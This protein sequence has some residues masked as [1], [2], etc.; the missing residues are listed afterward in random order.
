MIA[1]AYRVLRL[2]EWVLPARH[3][4][5]HVRAAPDGVCG[6]IAVMCGRYASTKTAADIAAEFHAVD[7]TAGVPP[8]PDYNIAP[9][10]SVLAVV[11]RHPRDGES[12]PDPGRTERSVR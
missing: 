4:S 8:G 1:H 6:S 7:A 3:L 12:T 11:R 5:G 10:K 9:T 2:W